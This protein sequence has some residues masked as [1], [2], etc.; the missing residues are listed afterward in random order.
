MNERIRGQLDVRNP[1]KF[2]HIENISRLDSSQLGP[3]VVIAAP[4]TSLIDAR[5]LPHAPFLI[6]VVSLSLPV[7]VSLSPRVGMLQN[8][9]SRQLFELWCDDDRNG[10]VRIYLFKAIDRSIDRTM[11][12]SIS[13]CLDRSIILLPLIPLCACRLWPGIM[14]RALWARSCSASR[15][16]SSVWTVESSRGGMGQKQYV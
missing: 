4:G 9:V 1:F 2:L 6:I 13:I 12:L 16:R 5:S 15:R 11:D 7:S 8:G 10:V 14:W 3:C